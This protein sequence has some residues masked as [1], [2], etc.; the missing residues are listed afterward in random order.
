M[1]SNS[2]DDDTAANVVNN[3]KILW[4]CNQNGISVTYTTRNTFL[5]IEFLWNDTLRMLF[6]SNAQ[7]P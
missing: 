6:H 1:K 7:N 3:L 2:N 4:D 5:Q